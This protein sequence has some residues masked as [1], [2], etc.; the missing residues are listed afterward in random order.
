MIFIV[1]KGSRN[2]VGEIIYA[3]MLEFTECLRNHYMFVLD[4]IRVSAFNWIGG[5]ASG[6]PNRYDVLLEDTFATDLYSLASFY[7]LSQAYRNL[8]QKNGPL[9]PSRMIRPTL[10]VYWNTLK[11]GVDEFSRALKTL[12]YTNTSENPI[13]SIVGRLISSQVGNAAIA[14]RLSI[15]RKREVLPDMNHE[16]CTIQTYKTLRHQV[17]SCESFGSFARELARE[18][19][20]RTQK[21]AVSDRMQSFQTSNVSQN[22]PSES[23]YQRK[24]TPMYYTNVVEKYNRA[25][26]ASRRLNNPESHER[27]KAKATYCSLCSYNHPVSYKGRKFQKKGGA[28]VVQWCGTCKQPICKNCWGAWHSK[29]KLQKSV[30]PAVEICRLNDKARKSMR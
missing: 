4:C 2:G 5:D 26:D 3:V 13:V 21:V 14:H 20:Q 7:N 8:V 1:A 29:T 18:Y 30:I 24:I 23:T 10:L 15:A 16:R 27:V 28:E 6:I 17:T 25:A 12:A 9:P 22:L 11:G 19:V